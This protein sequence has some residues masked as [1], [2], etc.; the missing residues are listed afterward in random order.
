MSRNAYLG[1][2]KVWYREDAKGTV[3]LTTPESPLPPGWQRYE[4]ATA[5][6]VERVWKR[7]DQQERRQA[8]KM[9]ESLFNNRKGKILEMKST[10]DA[11]KIAP[12]CTNAER[13]FIR[14]A[15]KI[16]NRKEDVLNRCSIFGV[17]AMQEKEAPVAASSTVVKVSDADTN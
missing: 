12:D 5:A 3:V 9:T 15:V 13:D 14:E 8:E 10:L 6:E 17:A 2:D 7:I 4:A 11:R 16:L 1:T